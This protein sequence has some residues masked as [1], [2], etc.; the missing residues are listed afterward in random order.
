MQIGAF[1]MLL[2]VKEEAP[3]ELAGF[4]AAAREVVAAPNIQVD[5]D[6]SS[7]AGKRKHLPWFILAALALADHGIKVFMHGTCGHTEGRLYTE[8]ALGFLNIPVCESW[9]QVDTEITQHNFAFMPL[10]RFCPKLDELIQLKAILGVRSA[11]HT[12][13]RLINPL[14]A[15][16]T[17]QSIFHPAYMEKHVIA[18]ELLQQP[19]MAVIKGDGGEIERRPEANSQVFFLH[20]HQRS[21]AQLDKLADG[22]LEEEGVANPELLQQLWRGELSHEYGDAAVIG[23]IALSLMVLG[24]AD[25]DQQAQQ[26]AQQIWQQR[27]RQRL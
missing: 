12:M 1:L 13:S 11:I 6:W 17:M 4:V 25:S 26:L 10:S 21:E 7:Y 9:Q 20:N 2:R 5:L 3:E 19:N 15:P 18:S 16:A 22:K 23:T 8:Q 27:N 24:K 14:A